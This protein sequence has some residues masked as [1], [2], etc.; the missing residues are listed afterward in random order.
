MED[1]DIILWAY[2]TS[3]GES[4]RETSFSLVYGGEAVIL[5]EIISDSPRVEGYNEQTNEETRRNELDLVDIN[6]EVA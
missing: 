1:L 2:R 4:T 3:P 6:K 5:V